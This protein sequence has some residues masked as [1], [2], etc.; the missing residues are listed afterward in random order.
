MADPSDRPL[1]KG[2][3]SFSSC[4]ADSG[5]RQQK[6]VNFSSQNEMKS[7]DARHQPPLLFCVFYDLSV[8]VLQLSAAD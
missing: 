1:F 6:Y 2:L 8:Q 3:D 7:A 5:N 4:R